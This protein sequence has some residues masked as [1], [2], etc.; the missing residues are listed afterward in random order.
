MGKGLLQLDVQTGKTLRT[1]MKDTVGKILFVAD[2]SPDGKMLA[3]GLI[4]RRNIF[5]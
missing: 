1:L 3:A 2:I 5:I 4:L